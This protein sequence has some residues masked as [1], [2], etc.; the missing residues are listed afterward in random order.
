MSTHRFRRSFFS[1]DHSS[2]IAWLGC[3]IL[4]VAGQGIAQTSY[5]AQIR[6]SVADPSSAVIIS[7]VAKTDSKGLYLLPNLRP[8]N[9]GIRAEAPGFRG[10]EKRNI[11]LQVEQQTTMDFALAPAGV[12][13]T[14]EVTQAA[15]LLDT[16]S[17]NL[18]TD[19]TNE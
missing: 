3:L 16:E 9:D 11:V 15:P 8:D 7:T 17:A 5:T 14:I 10:Q 13:T 4:L 6:G 1:G 2:G 12:A 18:G 19:I